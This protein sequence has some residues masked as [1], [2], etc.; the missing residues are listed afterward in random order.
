MNIRDV[1]KLHPENPKVTVRPHFDDSNV[2]NTT[3]FRDQWDEAFTAL[4][5]WIDADPKIRLGYLSSRAGDILTTLY[6][7][8]LSMPRPDYNII[9]QRGVMMY[10]GEPAAMYKLWM[11]NK[12]MF[13]DTHIDPSWYG[14]LSLSNSP[15]PSLA[16]FDLIE[17]VLIQ[18]DK[19][20]IHVE[21]DVTQECMIGLT[22]SGK[23][24]RD[25]NFDK[26]D[27]DKELT[28]EEVHHLM[29][30]TQAT[31]KDLHELC[32]LI[33]RTHDTKYMDMWRALIKD[34][35]LEECDS[36]LVESIRLWFGL[37]LFE[38]FK[39]TMKKVRFTLK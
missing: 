24:N 32:Y 6:C 5:E 15:Y 26:F 33:G 17:L 3:S 12:L 18:R 1:F 2:L 25:G 37:E 16:I 38:T 27:P 9:K 10:D 21:F 30:F 39:E 8:K 19:E 34:V 22:Y 7:L 36:M 23:M 13:Q 14:L 28:Y 20:T 29:P 31:D 35:L 11:P 4:N